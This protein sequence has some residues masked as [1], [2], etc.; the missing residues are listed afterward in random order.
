MMYETRLM[1]RGVVVAAFAGLLTACGGSAGPTGLA[2]ADLARGSGENGSGAGTSGGPSATGNLRLRCEVRPNR[3]KISVDGKNLS[4]RNGTFS[5]RV[6]ASGGSAVSGVATAI[7]DEVEFDF[8]SNRDDVAA[9]ATQ[10]APNFIT[11]R[12]GPDVVA[13]IRNAQGAVVASASAECEVR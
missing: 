7:G 10:I 4:P 13:Q 11:A 5:A 8:D 1:A 12:S 6:E 3:S 9:G 2:G